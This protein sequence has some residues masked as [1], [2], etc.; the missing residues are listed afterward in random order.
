MARGSQGIAHSLEKQANSE[1]NSSQLG[2]GETVSVCDCVNA[3]VYVVVL[4]SSS[5]SDLR[6]PLARPP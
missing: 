3:C 5:L 2:T 4:K 6:G 1:I